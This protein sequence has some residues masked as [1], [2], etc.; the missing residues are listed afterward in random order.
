MAHGDCCENCRHCDSDCYCEI[1]E[2]TVNPSSKC[3]EFEER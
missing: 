2:K 1:K 3:S